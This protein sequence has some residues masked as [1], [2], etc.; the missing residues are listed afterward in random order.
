MH[1]YQ[2]NYPHIMNNFYKKYWHFTYIPNIIIPNYINDKIRSNPDGIEVNWVYKNKYLILSLLNNRNDL[3]SIDIKFYPINY[4]NGNYHL[5]K[6]T[7]SLY[8]YNKFFCN[9]RYPYHP[10]ESAAYLF[11]DIILAQIFNEKLDVTCPAIKAFH[12]W[13]NKY[14]R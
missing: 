7:D 4:V 14:M 2:R 6:P 9:I 12:Q 13:L 5:G 1:I 3:S 10:N 11:S 8:E